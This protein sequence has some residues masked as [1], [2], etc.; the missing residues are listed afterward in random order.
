MMKTIER[1]GNKVRAP[2]VRGGFVW[3]V[4]RTLAPKAAPPKAEL[5]TSHYSNQAINIPIR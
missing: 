4:K 1:D 5:A 3:S 2:Q